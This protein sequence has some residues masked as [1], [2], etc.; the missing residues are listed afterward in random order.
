MI[1]F[2]KSMKISWI[3][4]FVIVFLAT[5]WQATA[6]SLDEGS[7]AYG[8]VWKDST[9][10]NLGSS[11]YRN[12]G[13]AS[14]GI[15]IYQTGYSTVGSD[16]RFTMQIGIEG[17]V[18]G[19][20]ASQYSSDWTYYNQYS[21]KDNV[22][23]YYV[24]RRMAIEITGISHPDGYDSGAWTGDQIA[25]NN[26]GL[27]VMVLNTAN[28]DWERFEASLSDANLVM[29]ALSLKVP[30][31]GVIWGGFRVAMHIRNMLVPQYP[32]NWG[33]YSDWWLGA[34]YYHS[35]AKVVW[36]YTAALSITPGLSSEYPT[37]GPEVAHASAWVDWRVPQAAINDYKIKVVSRISIGH[38][39]WTEGSP[40][41]GPHWTTASD[42]DVIDTRYVVFDP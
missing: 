2:R 36:D 32:S 12:S 17:V 20:S 40:L 18:P 42:Y 22:R 31:L 8:Y 10:K 34:P 21:N 39:V 1:K 28:A 23:H 9:W 30:Y 38:W 29:Y 26:E 15:A 37:I 25:N 14:T 41:V 3:L 5:P 13:G 6:Y 16:F 11:A 35:T 24:I 33:Y 27:G 4:L 7:T 19:L